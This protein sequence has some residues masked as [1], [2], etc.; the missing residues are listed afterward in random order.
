MI[1]LVATSVLPKQNNQQG[2]KGKRGD[3]EQRQQNR[4]SQGL[5]FFL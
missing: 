5:L 3:G 4:Q 1:V 2:T